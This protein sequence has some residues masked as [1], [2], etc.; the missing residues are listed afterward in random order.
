M[1]H[2]KDELAAFIDRVGGRA[3]VAARLNVGR[4]TVTHHIREREFPSSW[5]LGLC[6]MADERG[7][8]HPPSTMFDWKEVGP[9]PDAGPADPLSPAEIEQRLIQI[10]REVAA[11]RRS[12]EV[13]A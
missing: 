1:D 7:V 13:A 3:H 10:E 6:V 12:V 2:S 11:I 9:A 5:M 8:P 4:S